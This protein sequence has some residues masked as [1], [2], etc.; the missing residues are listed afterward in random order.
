V[1]IKR[2]LIV[3][4]SLAA[5]LISAGFYGVVFSTRYQE[6]MQRYAEKKDA[7]LLMTAELMVE[8]LWELNDQGLL[9]ISQTMLADDDVLGVAV[10]NEF[11]DLMLSLGEFYGSGLDVVE[12]PIVRM[13]DQLGIV[14]LAFSSVNIR[15]ALRKEIAQSSLMMALLVLGLNLIIVLATVSFTR[16]I[17]TL[18]ELVKGITGGQLATLPAIKA[19]GELAVLSDAIVNMLHELKKREETIKQV[20]AGAAESQ[21]KYQLEQYKFQTEQHLRLESEH[22]REEL[23]QSLQTLKTTQEH[24]INSEKLAVLGSL[25]AGVAHEINTPLGIGVTAAS[26]ISDLVHGMRGSLAAGGLELKTVANW[27]ETM[28]DSAKLLSGNL[29]RA[30]EIVRSFKQVS[31]DQA[32]EGARTFMMREYIQEIITSLHPKLKKGRHRVD[33]DCPDDLRV[34]TWPGVLAQILTNLIMNSLLHGFRGREEGLI[35]IQVSNCE[36]DFITL[37]YADDGAGLAVEE[38]PHLF[39]P[40]HTSLRN[41]G[42]SGLGTYI[43]YNLV[44]QKLGGM[45]SANS[46]PGQG[47]R[48]TIQFQPLAGC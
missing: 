23:Q 42:G 33:L 20:S 35:S 47:L 41:E 13:T 44:T 30:A 29:Q 45:I 11:G 12:A 15:L 39:E 27:V 8:S 34:N 43:I 10:I 2:R 31:V 9:R 22:L 5:S 25:V 6:E 46:Q 18:V 21:Y 37:T 16:P 36:N 48:Y 40:F 32:S 19:S 24:L 26:Y 1:T 7:W 17:Y 28:D 3:A 14:K 4:I 38:L